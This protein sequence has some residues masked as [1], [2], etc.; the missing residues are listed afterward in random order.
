MNAR[1]PNRRGEGKVVALRGRP[2]GAGMGANIP[3][4]PD[5]L[6]FLPAAQEILLT[7]PSP[8]RMWLMMSIC[9]LFAI[10]LIVSWLFKIDIYAVASARIQPAGRSKIVQPL[11]SGQVRA[12][13]V[14][15]G[16]RVE[17]GAL[18]LELDSTESSADRMAQ[19]GQLEALLAEIARRKAAIAAAQTARI[20]TSPKIMFPEEVGPAAR[21]REESVL[22]ADLSN[23]V[24]NLAALD[25]RVAEAVAERQALG[26]TIK[27]QEQLVATLSKRVEMQESLLE[28]QLGSRASV[29]DAQQNYSKEQASL[30]NQKGA[31]L[32]T[33]AAIVS[34][35]R[36]RDYALSTYIAANSQALATAETQQAEGAQRLVKA[37]ARLDYTK[38]VAPISGTVQELSVTTIGQ[39]VTGGQALM[40]IVPEDASLEAE[41]LVFNKDI[42][43]VETGQPAIIKIDAFP[44]TR[45]G[46]LTGTIRHVSHDA[47]SVNEALALADRISGA[48]QTPGAV[49][50]MLDLVYPVTVELNETAIDV[51][52]RMIELTPGM[53]ARV[54][55]RTGERRVLEYF[56]SPLVKAVS[57]SARER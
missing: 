25:G 1:Y 46:T 52:G 44:F 47:V 34:L 19:A 56:L 28:R 22:A 29:M 18:L 5:D 17:Q 7:P 53:S 11:E 36:E 51:D 20:S 50:K 21:A 26:L 2:P 14:E 30:A 48:G 41:A 37:S 31:L 57:E 40:A 9:A 27:E 43:F 35:K 54:E 45:Y 6:E 32:R 8:I 23:L 49:P 39:V 42:A 16:M 15:N 10:A 3:I 38:I 55:I 33:D 24:S 12:L 4:H 13:H